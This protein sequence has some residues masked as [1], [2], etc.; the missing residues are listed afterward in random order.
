MEDVLP[1][2]TA[3]PLWEWERLT[4]R[5]REGAWR[6][7][8][9]WVGYVVIGRYLLG[10]RLGSCWYEHPEMVDCIIRLHEAEAELSPKMHSYQA[11]T[12]QWEDQLAACAEGWPARCME[13]GTGAVG[14]PPPIVTGTLDARPRLLLLD[15]CMRVLD[16]ALI[17]P[18][19]RI[20]ESTTAEVQPILR[21]AGIKLGPVLGRRKA[22]VR[23][24]I[25][26]MLTDLA[27][28]ALEFEEEAQ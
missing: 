27:R 18:G 8:T 25:G 26:G 22:R 12:E 9:D 14:N 23:E 28:E 1:K 16:A 13:H 11:L 2:R 5:D 19:D 20:D 10:D 15:H 24:Q 17:Q 3:S 7:L 6:E 21:R 4:A